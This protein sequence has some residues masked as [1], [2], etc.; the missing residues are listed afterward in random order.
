VSAP[1]G[2]SD[3][4]QVG[5]ELSA[6]VAAGD[7]DAI[8]QLYVA[9]GRLVYTIAYRILSDSGLAEDATQTAFTKL[10]QAA[11]RVEPTSDIRPLLFTITRRV[12]FDMSQATR[13][14]GWTPLQ[15]VDDQP[16]PDD[17]DRLTIEW[18]VRDAVD[19]L[20][21]DE[22]LIVH[23]QHLQGLTHTEIAVR[24]G[25]PVGTVKSRS[26][27]AHKRLLETLG[28]LREEVG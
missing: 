6:L 24:L 13:R 28:P 4:E 9:Y 3:A 1:R 27:R 12:A 11:A 2:P 25:M 5:R 22:R 7:P 10:W 23:L 18:E 8:R 20:P 19:A 15:D 14:R 16:V 21:P 17:L 26:H